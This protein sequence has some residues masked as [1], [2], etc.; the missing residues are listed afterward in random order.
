ME[1]SA[2][3][4]PGDSRRV[5]TVAV[6]LLK[7]RSE[8]GKE[9]FVQEAA[10]LSPL[11]H[12]NVCALL[13][14]CFQSDPLLIVLEFMPNGDLKTLLRRVQHDGT[15]R[16]EHL[17]HIAVD[18]GR[19]VQFLSEQR[20]VHRDLA[21]RNVMLSAAFTCKIGDFGMARRLFAKEYYA[22]GTS[23]K[24]NWT[25]PIRWMAPESFTDG[26]W[27]VKTD[28]WMLGVLLWEV[29]SW[30]ALP[31]G[32]VAEARIVAGIQQTAKLP[33]P[34]LCPP[35]VY[36]A[37]YECWRLDRARRCS[38]E[39]VCA[40]IEQFASTIDMSGVVWPAASSAG[41]GAARRT[42]ARRRSE[43]SVSALD[44]SSAG[45]E[46]AF[47]AFEVSPD[48]I[49]V[50]SQLGK[51]QFGAV[52][53]GVLRGRDGGVVDVAVK[54]MLVADVPDIELQRFEYEARLLACLSHR[55][56]VRL[57]GVCFASPPPFIVL[58]LMSNG[59]LRSF[60]RKRAEQFDDSSECVAALLGACLQIAE[61]MVYL[62]ALNIVHRDLAARCA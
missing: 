57:L 19:G 20:Y 13:A 18:C 59:D 58:E 41:D 49:E 12:D 35:P 48:Q 46:R 36:D 51:G 24:S 3:N 5:T 50:R 32:D 4:L 33:C 44:L 31:W 1:A 21:A 27:D 28:V 9:A 37:M 39:Q 10:R 7:D 55:N 2:V 17:L 56:I 45:A 14:V 61:A 60:L 40:R 16:L 6:K 54:R 53:K 62:S 8:A 52:H 30:A 26:T 22:Q 42:T 34:L 15:I 43:A 38:A 29:F 23:G 11:K 47:A 25:L